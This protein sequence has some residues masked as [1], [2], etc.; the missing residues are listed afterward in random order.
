MHTQKVL[1]II[2]AR[3]GSK[4]IPKKNIKEFC[5]KPMIGWPLSVLNDGDIV[6]EIIVS[7]DSEEIAKV[8]KNLGAK[9]PF[10]RPSELADDFTGTAAVV[11]H[12]VEW[13]LENIGSVE[14]V[15]TVYPTAVFL[16]H[17]DIE[18]AF[19]MLQASDLEIVFS[20]T[21]YPFP[22]QRAVY[23]DE[24]QRVT[25]FQP[26]HYSSRSQDLVK[27]YHDAG[28][29]YFAKLSAVLNNISAFSKA[30]RMLVLPRHRV[31]DIDTMEDF[32]VAERLFKVTT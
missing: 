17:K 30:S 3:G 20:G 7:T 19:N 12:A 14:Y 13:Y 31:V 4:R 10:M 16:S 25:L 22:I 1:A 26:E 9:I 29:F 15:L 2:P 11:K 18:A 24:Q 5:G 27:A 23:L 6:D 8:A 21:E 28:Q 32:E